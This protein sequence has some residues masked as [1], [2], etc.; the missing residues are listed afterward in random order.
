MATL[1]DGKI[2][3]TSGDQYVRYSDA[4]ASTVDRGYPKPIA[5]NLGDLPAAFEAGFDS[6]TVLP[7]GK[8]YVTSGAQYLRYDDPDSTIVGSRYPMQI[9]GNWSN[10][11]R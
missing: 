8:T 7:N 1:P 2:Y 11:L 9:A 3:V 4:N 6:M 5:G 10:S